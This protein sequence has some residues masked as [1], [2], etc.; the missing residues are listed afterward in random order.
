[1]CAF[2]GGDLIQHVNHG[3][4]GHDI[5]FYDGTV[6]ETNTIHHQMI[7]PFEK[8]VQG[9]D[10]YIVANS[11]GLSNVHQ[12]ETNDNLDLPVNENGV[13]L[14]PETAFF[15]KINGFGHQSHLEMQSS[16]SPVVRLT[17][18]LVEHQVKGTLEVIL[19]NNIPLMEI[20]NPEF[21]INKIIKQQISETV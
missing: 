12:G 17:R 16:Q 21:D 1:M 9:E 15:P 7:Y 11:L 5:T 8:L 4:W 10:Y 20:I 2:A 3:G 6:V 19:Q 18:K 13:K 14:E